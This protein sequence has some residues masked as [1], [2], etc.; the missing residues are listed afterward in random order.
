MLSCVAPQQQENAHLY[1]QGQSQLHRQLASSLRGLSAQ[2]KATFLE[3]KEVV[4]MSL[5]GIGRFS[6]L[7]CLFVLLFQCAL[8]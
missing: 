5:I 4:F 7:V 3:K 8:D 2:N 6:S 1:L